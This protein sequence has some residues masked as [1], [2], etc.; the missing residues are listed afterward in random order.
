LGNKSPPIA[1]IAIVIND[2][3]KVKNNLLKIEGVVLFFYSNNLL[4]MVITTFWT[5][6]MWKD[7]FLAVGTGNKIYKR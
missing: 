6:A 1:S 2:I 4:A 5:N 3:E 7:H